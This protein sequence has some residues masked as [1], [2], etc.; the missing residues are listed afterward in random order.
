MGENSFHKGRLRDPNISQSEGF[1]HRCLILHFV[2]DDYVKIQCQQLFG[3]LLFSEKFGH[4]NE[5]QAL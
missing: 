4:F 3:Y 5:G 2:R 1:F